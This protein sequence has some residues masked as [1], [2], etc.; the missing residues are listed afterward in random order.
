[1]W[2]CSNDITEFGSTFNGKSEPF[3]STDTLDPPSSVSKSSWDV[4][5]SRLWPPFQIQFSEVFMPAMPIF[6][7]P[8]KPT[9]KQRQTRRHLDSGRDTQAGHNGD[10][11]DVR[12]THLL[13]HRLG[14]RSDVEINGWK[15]HNGEIC[16][17]MEQFR[18]ETNG[19]GRVLTDIHNTISDHQSITA[20]WNPWLPLSSAKQCAHSLAGNHPPAIP[21][22]SPCRACCWTSSTSANG[23]CSHFGLL[24]CNCT[25]WILCCLFL[26]SGLKIVQV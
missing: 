24:L 19:V 14:I 6:C 2:S 9:F 20:H 25:P 8:A 5:K 16:A 1:M 23:A 4:C 3:S 12:K 21:S 15:W 11:T 18:W 13:H 26:G 7:N 22:T 10:T 17:E